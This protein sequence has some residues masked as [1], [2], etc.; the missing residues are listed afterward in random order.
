MNKIEKIK[1]EKNCF[2]M[3]SLSG[4]EINKRGNIR[5]P[6]HDDNTPSFYSDHII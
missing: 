2:D 6:W 1:Q 5:C 3:L 4:I